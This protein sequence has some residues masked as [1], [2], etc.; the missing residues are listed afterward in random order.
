MRSRALLSLLESIATQTSYPNEIL[1]I[2]GS[3]NNETEQILKVN[4]FINLKY[5]KIGDD[6]RG[7]TKQRNFGVRQVNEASEVVCFLDDD[8]L[9]DINYFKVLLSTY[10][11]HP[12]ALAVGGYITNEVKWSP[13]SDNSESHV[14]SFDG[15]Q[16]KEPLRYRLRALFSLLPN[17]A[18]GFFPDFGHGR[19]ISFLPPS[20]KIYETELFMGGVSSYKKEIFEN[21]RF[22]TYFEG[23]GLYEDADFCLRLAKKGQLYVNTNAKCQHY[24]D[25]SG[26]PDSYKYGKMVVRNGWYIFKTKF[27][28]P[29][30]KMKLKWLFTSMLLT[31][32]KLLNIITEPNRNAA[33]KEGFGRIIGWW[34][35]VF[36]PPKARKCDF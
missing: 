3:T 33:F 23:Y 34:S 19:P 11:S 17:V 32:I 8:I 12:N 15:W 27:E 26:R 7:L 20:N 6:Q 2:D 16:R 9:L 35:V 31:K 13:L 28:N 30:F 21:L 10:H 24:H 5:F 22:S 14:F 1:I 29:T 25:Q 18:P 4:P 36:N